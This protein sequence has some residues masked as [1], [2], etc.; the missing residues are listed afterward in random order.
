MPASSR[1]ACVRSDGETP[2][3]QLH[4]QRQEVL[5][6]A[7][8]EHVELQL[9]LAVLGAQQLTQHRV[10]DGAEVDGRQLGAYDVGVGLELAVGELGLGLATLDEVVAQV[11]GV[12]RRD[13]EEEAEAAGEQGELVVDREVG[14]TEL[15]RSPPLTAAAPAP[16]GGRAASPARAARRQLSRSSSTSPVHSSM[17]VFLNSSASTHPTP[18]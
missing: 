13:V 6:V 17:K 11:V 9:H 15:R 10:L 2:A 8:L 7:G 14:R 18:G 16:R 12:D 4:A 1:S 5:G 3:V